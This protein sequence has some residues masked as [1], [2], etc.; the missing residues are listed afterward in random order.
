VSVEEQNK[1]VVK[2]FWEEVFNQGNLDVADELFAPE[3][4]LYDGRE[5]DFNDELRGPEAVRD[6]VER[7]RAEFSDLRVLVED[8]MAAEADHVVTRFA[9]SATREGN[10]VEVKGI[11]FSQVSDG[12]ITGSRVNW[13]SGHMYEQ[14]GGYFVDSLP[15]FEDSPPGFEGLAPDE[16]VAFE[17]FAFLRLKIPPWN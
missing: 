14:L 7:I 12:K 16:Q 4:V 11:S 9:V 13:E 17:Q 6:L 10:P 3:W 8:Q 5:A 15:G 1:A 2:R